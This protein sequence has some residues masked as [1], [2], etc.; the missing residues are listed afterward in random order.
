MNYTSEKKM[1]NDK[2]IVS[3]C[4]LSYNHHAYIRECLEGFV[5]QKTDFAFEVLIYDDAS[6]DE[7]ANIIREYEK[8]HPDII[9]PIYQ[10]E[11]QYSKGVGVTRKY[12]F[13]RAKGKYI[14]MCEGDDYWIDPLK[15]QKQVDFLEANEE[16]GV[17][18]SDANVYFENT[19]K[20]VENINKLNNRNLVN[21]D[22]PAEGIIL[23][24]YSI[25]TLTSLFRISLLDN[26]DMKSP[27]KF[28]MG[29]L[30]LWLT[31]T[32]FTKFYYID[33]PMAVYR[34][35]EG[36]ASNPLNKSAK[37]DFK[38]SSK[39]VRLFFAKSLKLKTSTINE[40]SDQ[41]NRAVLRKKFEIIESTKSSK[42]F[43]SI[44][45]KTLKDVI[46]LV[47]CKSKVLNSIVNKIIPEM[48]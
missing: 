35:S 29:D 30:P 23:G 22:N 43:F 1:V 25:Y 12:N 32:K 36:S 7:T 42:V 26:I 34:K 38:I 19:R 6:T 39:E 44:H 41:Y 9:K 3:V 16:Y 47:G 13:A 31:F 17:V 37:L 2:V 40:V 21:F 14:A 18:H 11:N 15:L 45:K 4:C 20:L 27:R 8:K 28:E 33:E 5:L 46:L 24:S 48:S 10:T